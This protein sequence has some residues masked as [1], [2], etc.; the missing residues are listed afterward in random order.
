MQVSGGE[1]AVLMSVVNSKKKIKSQVILNESTKTAFQK[2]QNLMTQIIVHAAW[3]VLLLRSYHSF[4][5]KPQSDK[6]DIF[7]TAKDHCVGEETSAVSYM[8]F[9]TLHSCNEIL[10]FKQ[11]WKQ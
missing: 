9:T 3:E 2:V 10:P 6:R 8:T 4:L 7:G 5:L 11:K 1:K